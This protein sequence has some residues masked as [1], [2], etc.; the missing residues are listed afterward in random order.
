MRSPCSTR[1]WSSGP[2]QQQRFESYGRRTRRRV[3]APWKLSEA[4]DG[5]EP[6]DALLTMR[7]ATVR[8]P[9]TA[10]LAHFAACAQTR[11]AIGCDR[12]QRLDSIKGP[13][14]VGT[15]G[16]V[17][18]PRRGRPGLAARNTTAY[19][20]VALVRLP[21]TVRTRS[22]ARTYSSSDIAPDSCS[23]ARLAIWSAVVVSVPAGGAARVVPARAR[24]AGTRAVFVCGER[25]CRRRSARRR[26]GSSAARASGPRG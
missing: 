4:L 2:G 9:T 20:R 23:A 5:L 7:A 3:D 24:C 10:V 17:N 21:F 1:S 25:R 18:A 14:V 12:L 19:W 26:G 13:S 6:F 8:K 16:D 15:L 11:S 22:L